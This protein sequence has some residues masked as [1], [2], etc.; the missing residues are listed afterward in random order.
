MDITEDRWIECSQ[1]ESKRENHGKN[2]VEYKINVIIVLKEERKGCK[3]YGLSR[4]R[5]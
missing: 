1:T 3:Q 5:G 2:S 4:D